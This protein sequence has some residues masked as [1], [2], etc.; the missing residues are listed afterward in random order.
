M[1]LHSYITHSQ[2]EWVF[3]C[4][5]SNCHR[6]RQAVF[7]LHRIGSNFFQFIA[8]SCHVSFAKFTLYFGSDILAYFAE[9][10]FVLLFYFV[11]LYCVLFL[12]GCCCYFI[13]N[14]PFLLTFFFFPYKPINNVDWGVILR[15]LYLFC[16]PNMVIFICLIELGLVWPTLKITN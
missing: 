5:F 14:W 7:L 13:F 16:Y 9:F 10:C 3:A 11:L 2:F 12:F 15:W 1:E 8:F 4:L 6:R